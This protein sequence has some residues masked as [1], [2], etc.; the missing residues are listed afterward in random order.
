MTHVPQHSEE[1]GGSSY[2]SLSFNKTPER[3]NVRR[4]GFVCLGIL[5][6]QATI[7]GVVWGQEQ[8]TP[9]VR[10]QRTT[11]AVLSCFLPRRLPPTM[12]LKPIELV[13]KITHHSTYVCFERSLS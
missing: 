1:G 4:D 2:F 3:S 9:T 10:N 13:V 8:D 11:N 6:D 12:I 5:G 7:A